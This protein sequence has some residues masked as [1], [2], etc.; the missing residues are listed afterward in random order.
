M[1]TFKAPLFS[2]VLFHES[3]RQKVVCAQKSRLC[4]VDTTILKA[5]QGDARVAHFFFIF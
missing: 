2:Q 3:K 5:A 1:A 4:Y